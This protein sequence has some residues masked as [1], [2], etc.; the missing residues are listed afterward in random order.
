VG[1]SPEEQMWALGHSQLPTT[2]DY[3]SEGFD[4]TPA[5]APYVD[6]VA[7]ILDGTLVVKN[8]SAK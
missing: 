4:R 5:L 2:M 7:S 1:A 8:G 6:K 3:G